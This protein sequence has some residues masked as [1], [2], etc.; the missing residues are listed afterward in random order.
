ME[1]RGIR[2]IPPGF[3]RGLRLPGEGEDETGLDGL[4]N[5]QKH[6]AVGQ[7]DAVSMPSQHRARLSYDLLHSHHPR[8]YNPRVYL[9]SEARKSMTYYRHR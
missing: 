2:T 4:G 7:G 9:S 1:G 3:A 8:G 5:V 6:L